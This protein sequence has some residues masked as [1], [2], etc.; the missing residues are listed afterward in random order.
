MALKLPPL[1]AQTPI[2]DAQG[3]PTPQ[4]LQ[5]WQRYGGAIVA[6]FNGQQAALEAAGIALSAAETATT[7]A[8]AAQSAADGTTTATAL[9][10]SSVTGLTLTATDA[11]AN[12]TITIS[13]HTRRYGD[14][15]TAAIS[16]GTLTGLAYST[17][18]WIFYD[19]DKGT[20]GAVTYQAATTVQGNAT[21]ATNRHFV[22]A[23]TTPAALGSPIDGLPVLPPGGVLP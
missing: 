6:A 1:N 21:G 11:G 5:F 3:R 8:E 17:D 18:Y 10:N 16:G 19:A 20:A 9:A 22:G 13:A 2:V 14:G 4:F 23:V 15:T 7:A 12:A